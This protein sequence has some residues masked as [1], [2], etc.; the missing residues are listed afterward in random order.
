MSD[1]EKPEETELVAE[2]AETPESQ[3]TEEV[4]PIEKVKGILLL[5]L[6]GAVLLLFLVFVPKWLDQY[7]GKITDGIT[8][9]IDGAMGAETGE[10][11]EP[12]KADQK[13]ESPEAD[14]EKTDQ[15]E[16]VAATKGGHSVASVKKQLTAAL[17]GK[18]RVEVR[19]VAIP[20]KQDKMVAALKGYDGE[21]GSRLFE[22]FFDKD[23]YGRFVP[24]DTRTNREMLE[25]ALEGVDTETGR[26]IIW[27]E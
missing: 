11:E 4:P 12:D 8:G 7:A 3:T 17:G 5:L 25:S 2:S 22:L 20:E 26:V 13:S 15:A 18:E 6:V 23:E 19:F 24:A 21:G 27:P 9:T 1:E 16:G 14:S 10:Q